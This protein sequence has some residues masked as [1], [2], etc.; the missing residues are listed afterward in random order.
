M[1][2]SFGIAGERLS[3]RSLTVDDV[4]E[5]Y[6]GWLNDPEVTRYLESRHAT[7]SIQS[8]TDF[9]RAKIDDPHALFLGMFLN[10]DNRHIGNVKL[11]PIDP[12]NRRAEVGILLGEKEFWGKNLATEALELTVHV[13][14]EHLGLH[15]LTAGCYGNNIGSMKAFQKAG[16]SVEG[17]RKSHYRYDDAWVDLILLGIVAEGPVVAADQRPTT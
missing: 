14:F 16:F 3:L 12:V 13:G 5:R 10:D 17:I 15:K 7:H 11:E 6:V 4:G 8:V 9:V 1:K 2:P